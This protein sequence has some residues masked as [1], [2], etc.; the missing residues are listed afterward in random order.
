MALSAEPNI[1]GPILVVQYIP[2]SFNHAYIAPAD[3]ME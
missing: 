1:T 3:N 2:L